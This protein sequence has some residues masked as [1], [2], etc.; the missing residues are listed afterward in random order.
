MSYNFTCKNNRKI[1]IRKLKSSDAKLVLDYLC[2]VGGETDYLLM[3]SQGLGIEI[4]EEERILDRFY[5][6]PKAL[7]LGCFDGDELVA[8][9]NL[10]TKEREKIKHIST[11]GISVKKQYWNLGIGKN[12][13]SF[14][15]NFAMKNEQIE[16]I[17]LEVRSDNL[18]A[19]HLYESLGFYRVGLVPKAMKIGNQYYENLIM[20]LN[21]K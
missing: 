14:M 15:I 13:M 9:S 2:L 10:S 4:D 6:N 19:I 16:V 3:D 12:L 8:V 1:E 20:I 11:L 17:Q 7:L 21:V 18:S 5:N